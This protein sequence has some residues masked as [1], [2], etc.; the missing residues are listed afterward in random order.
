MGLM[1]FAKVAVRNLFSKPYT[2]NYPYE[3]AVYPERSRGRILLDHSKCVL[4]G[5]CST[6]CPT[7][8]IFIDRKAGTWNM[9]RFDC[10]QCGNCVKV[11]PKS[12]LSIVPGYFTPNREKLIET[13]QIKAPAA[14]TGKTTEPGA[15]PTG[16]AMAV[17]VVNDACI[18]C[19]ACAAQCPAGAITVGDGWSVN[20]EA[21]LGCEGCI[22]TCPENALSMK[23]AMAPGHEAAMAASDKEW[24][25][26]RKLG[27]R[28]Y[29]PQFDK[30][31]EEIPV[32]ACTLPDYVDEWADL[33]VSTPENCVYCGLCSKQC[34]KGAIVVD[35]KEKIWEVDNAEC[36]RC[37]ICVENCP[38][39]ALTLPD[40]T[41][42]VPAEEEADFIIACL[43]PGYN[44]EFVD[45]PR[46]GD[47]CVYCSLC[48]KKCP[49][50]A[51]TV[52]RKTKTWTVDNELC[53]RC[54]VCAGVCPK[55]CI[56]L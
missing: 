8:T 3:P 17:P 50:G 40:V 24:G 51:L 49:A 52:D 14:F 19:G 21:C 38:K 16:P 18:L 20:A 13:N 35:R 48:A 7:D 36:I 4:C 44:D 54:G 33:P 1:T 11:C 41:M 25:V 55:K 53:V 56:D 34:P 47:A 37:G 29:V 31:G 10:V 42:D 9:N 12:A 15:I 5:L 27:R 39:Q 28:P 45:L 26:Q 2:T 32:P 30:D 23:S 46:K 6:H 22:S 43:E